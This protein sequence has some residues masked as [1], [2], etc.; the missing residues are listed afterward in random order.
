VEAA[1][2]LRHTST[3]GVRTYQKINSDEPE[4][5]FQPIL[6]PFLA[7]VRVCAPMR[8]RQHIPPTPP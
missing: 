3:F 7:C 6:V 8:V 5:I 2:K 4:A 1:S